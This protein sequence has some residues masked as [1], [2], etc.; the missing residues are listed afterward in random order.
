MSSTIPHTAHMQ[1]S[2]ISLLA[3]FLQIIIIHFQASQH[4]QSQIT[5]FVCFT[6][7]N[8]ESGFVR[9][10]NWPYWKTVIDHTWSYQFND[11]CMHIKDDTWSFLQ[12]HLCCDSTKD[13]VTKKV[14][15]DRAMQPICS[16]KQCLACSIIN[17]D[18]RL[19][20]K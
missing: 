2:W 15:T 5:S 3:S 12:P 19:K 7:I 18:Y 6:Q 14:L 11:A 1:L 10:N 16:F 13:E 20:F 8:K 9:S 4:L 17:V